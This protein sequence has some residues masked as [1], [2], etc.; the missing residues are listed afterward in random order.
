MSIV[1]SIA[2][3][4]F[5][6][7]TI[8]EWLT[9]I[10]TIGATAVA[11]WLAQKDRRIS[12]KVTVGERVLL[13]PGVP[14]SDTNH[15]AISVVNR[16]PRTANIESIY[17]RVGFWWQR[18]SHFYQLADPRS[19]IFSSKIPYELAYGKTANYFYPLDSWLSTNAKQLLGES[20]W[21]PKWVAKTI[22]VEIYTSTGEVV[23]KHIEPRLEKSLIK[24]FKTQTRATD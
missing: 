20:S 18:K 17:W 13:Q 6:T 21:P 9:A 5:W 1:L 4:D 3:D 10:G 22:K 19:A 11:L 2:S 23:R 8:P 15:L 12:L 7:K 14:G 16:G 24:A